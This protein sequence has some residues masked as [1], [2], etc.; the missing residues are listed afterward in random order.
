MVFIS[1]TSGADSLP[2]TADADIILGLGGGDTIV[3]LGDDDL[4][5]GGSGHDLIFGAAIATSSD[6]TPLA[7]SDNDTIYGGAGNDTVYGGAQLTGGDS[8]NLIFGG[9]G[10]DL[11]SGMHG[12]ARDT[13][14]GG[15]GGDTIIGYGLLGP[16]IPSNAFLDVLRADPAD[17]LLGGSRNDSIDGGGGNDTVL[18]GPGA[19]TIIGHF[20]A[21]Q[22]SGDAGP[23]RFVF[24]PPQP[25]FDPQ[26]LRASP[27]TGVGEGNR[28]VVWDFRHGKDHLDLSAYEA[29]LPIPQT[30]PPDFPEPVFLGTDPFTASFGLQVRYEVLDDHR[31][32]VQFAATLVAA[33]LPADAEPTV[34][35]QPT[36]EI[37]VVGIREL[38]ADD[39]IL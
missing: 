31:I 34:P 27:D 23:D 8:G 38:K 1:G 7:D 11:I 29:P 28:D 2:G 17:L 18:G 21:D 24:R 3:G 22:L 25:P 6:P 26:P 32:L 39:L 10:D 13:I 14:L 30:T 35:Q 16:G 9:G 12:M 20:G 36:G 37:E 15:D 19:D 4:L 5:L 33:G